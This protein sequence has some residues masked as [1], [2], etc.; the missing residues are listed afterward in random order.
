[1]AR[2]SMQILICLTCWEANSW[3]A[4]ASKERSRNPALNGGTHDEIGE[5]SS[6]TRSPPG[7]NGQHHRRP[8]EGSRTLAE[9]LAVGCLRDADESDFREALSRRQRHP[10][11]DGR[12]AQGL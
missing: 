5:R 6:Q 11:D 7:S 3:K 1:M 8:R 2:T 4:P 12:D 9:A 10:F